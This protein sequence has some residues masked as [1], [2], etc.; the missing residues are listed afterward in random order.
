MLGV[1]VYRG[2]DDRSMRA[3]NTSAFNCRFVGG[4]RRWSEHAYGK[5]ID[6]NPV[7]NPYVHGGLVEPPAGRAYLDRS[8]RRPGWQ[9]H[10]SLVVR[11]FDSAGTGAAAGAR[12][13]TTST[14]RR[15]SLGILDPQAP[16]QEWVYA[17]DKAA[18]VSAGP[19]AANDQEVP[20]T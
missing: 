13:R 7:E 8:S 3:D 9:P 5:A 17:A 18:R 2:S 4:T 12:R 20:R 11:A 16:L 10:A 6:L 15:T 1:E 14:S 19:R